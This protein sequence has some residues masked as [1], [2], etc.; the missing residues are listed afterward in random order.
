MFAFRILQLYRLP[1]AM[2]GPLVVCHGGAWAIPDELD[3]ASRTGVMRAAAAALAVLEA[4]GDA[5][6]GCE[7]A[8][9]VLE[10]AECFDAG[11]GSVLNED[12]AVEMDSAV[13]RGRDLGCG[14]VAGVSCVRNPVSLA[15]GV[16]E[17]TAHCMLAGEGPTR[18]F[19][20][21]LGMEIVGADELVCQA[22][23]DEY[24]RFKEFS[25]QGGSVESLFSGSGHDTVGCV[26]RDSKGSLAAATSTGGITAKKA[27]RV[28]DSPIIGSGA[29]ADDEAGAVSTTGHG[30]SILK[31]C[32]AKGV[33]DKLRRGAPAQLTAP[34][35][36]ASALANMQER[37][38]GRGGVI[39]IDSSGEPGIGYSTEKMAWAV[40]RPGR[41]TVGG[42]HAPTAPDL[43]REAGFANAASDAKL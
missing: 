38:N 32:L 25:G 17:Q 9:R 19:A 4:G 5:L 11:R 18:K 27:G 30:E 20:Q 6:D 1:S 12:G 29:Y 24:E 22:A 21:Q 37:V 35:A 3:E 33:V 34:V 7:A 23:V 26:C 14:A 13:M 40:A 41:A 2:S 43:R 16:L 10:D 15:R 36:V 8:V 42:I 31:V 28:G 39:C